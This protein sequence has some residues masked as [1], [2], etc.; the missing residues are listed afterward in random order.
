[1]SIDPERDRQSEQQQDR[2]VIAAAIAALFGRPAAIRHITGVPGHGPE[3]WTREGRLAIQ[4]S[5]GMPAPLIRRA[6]DR[7]EGNL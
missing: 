4:R 5:H 6:P 7:G 2:V 1:M 3:A